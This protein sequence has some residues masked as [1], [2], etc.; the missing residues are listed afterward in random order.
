MTSTGPSS[1]QTMAIERLQKGLQELVKYLRDASGCEDASEIVDVLAEFSA[2]LSSQDLHALPVEALK[3][4]EQ[5][6]ITL[7]HKGV[8][9]WFMNLQWMA[10]N[11]NVDATSLVDLIGGLKSLSTDWASTALSDGFQPSVIFTPEFAL[12]MGDRLAEVRASAA[13]AGHTVA[14]PVFQAPPAPRANPTF[15]ATLIPS[16]PADRMPPA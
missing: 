6:L 4:Y 9:D 11:R 16:T 7:V 1:A 2:A 14:T 5:V 10:A 15:S 8:D 12:H 13:A 3:E